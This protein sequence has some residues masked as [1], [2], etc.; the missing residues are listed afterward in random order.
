MFPEA[1]GIP[2]HYPVKPVCLSSVLLN[3]FWK[4]RWWH[5]VKLSNLRLSWTFGEERNLGPKHALKKKKSVMEKTETFAKADGNNKMN[6]HPA[7]ANFSS[8]PSHPLL[9][10]LTVIY[11]LDVCL[12]KSLSWILCFSQLTVCLFTEKFMV[13]ACLCFRYASLLIFSFCK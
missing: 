4:F 11:G 9:F 7:P 13:S 1:V 8:P 6:P 5:G 12:V 2:Y 3:Y 10:F